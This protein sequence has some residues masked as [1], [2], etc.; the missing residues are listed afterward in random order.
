MNNRKV[1]IIVPIYNSEKLLNVAIDSVLRQTLEDI[2]IILV[3]DGS[4][5]NSP[6][7][8][9]DYAKKD[10]RVVVIHKENAGQAQARNDGLK[11]AKRKIYNVFRC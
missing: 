6:K 7:I 10:N 11:V 9:D 2:E 1:S 3:D 4:K 5:D 8:C